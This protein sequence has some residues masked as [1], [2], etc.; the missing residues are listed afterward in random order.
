[1]P[2]RKCTYSDEIFRLYPS[3]KKGK[4]TSE[5][6][7]IVCNS[8]ISIAHKGKLDIETHIK[9]DKHKQMLKAQAGTSAGLQNFVV[10]SGETKS[11]KAAEATLAFHTVCHH[12]SYKSMDCTMKVNL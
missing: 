5:V 12:Q 1:M 2:K 3:F 7:C 9:K 11:I 4:T 10:T 6:I 8:S